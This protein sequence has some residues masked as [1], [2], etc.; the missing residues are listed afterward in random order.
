MFCKQCGTQLAVTDTFC[1]GCGAKVAPSPSAEHPSPVLPVE[2]E[3]S[4][5][6]E[7]IVLSPPVPV[8]A[9]VP[10]EAKGSKALEYKVVH[11]TPTIL[12]G[13]SIH[14]AADQ[15]EAL[16]NQYS[17]Q[18]WSYVR[19]ETLRMIERTPANK[20]CIGI[21]ATPEVIHPLDIYVVVFSR[22]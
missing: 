19:I 9:A 6:N 20:G 18:G 5:K 22:S 8:P 2:D 4:G 21:G 7:A 16:I 10:V 15:L 13:E 14:K 12:K 17:R 1:T 3:Q 11:Y